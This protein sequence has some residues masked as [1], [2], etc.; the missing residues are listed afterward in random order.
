MWLYIF[1]LPIHQL[2]I[3]R[4]FLLW[5]YYEKY[6]YEYSC[7]SLGA[8]V[9]TL[10]DIYIELL[11]YKLNLCIKIWGVAKVLCKRLTSFYIAAQKFLTLMEFILSSFPFVTFGIL[12][13]IPLLKPRSWKFIPMFST[14]SFIAL[15]LLLKFMFHFELVFVWFNVGGPTS[16]YCTWISSCLSTIFWK[17]YFLFIELSWHSC[18]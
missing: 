10:L 4:L 15:T 17:D 7:I 2:M 3:S 18:Q 13:K 11:D 8:H 1:Y 9:F 5:G 14:K 12:F 6:C 16:F